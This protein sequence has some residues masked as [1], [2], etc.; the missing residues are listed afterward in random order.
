MIK[1]P[2]NIPA[3]PIPAIALPMIRA[4]EFGA[5]PQTKDPTS[6]INIPMR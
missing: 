5:I 2:E 3:L 4:V 6:K 1:A